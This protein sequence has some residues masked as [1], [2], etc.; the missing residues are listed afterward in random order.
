MTVE[1]SFNCKYDRWLPAAS[2]HILLIE[3]HAGVPVVPPAVLEKYYPKA[4]AG[5]K[6]RDGVAT[7]KGTRI[8]FVEFSRPLGSL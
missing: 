7:V 6:T 8:I 4:S 1:Y 2:G 5:L 3:T